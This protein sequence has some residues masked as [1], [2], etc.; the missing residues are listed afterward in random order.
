MVNDVEGSGRDL[1]E[2]LSWRK[3]AGSGYITQVLSRDSRPSGRHMHSGLSEHEAVSY[4]LD[5]RLSIILQPGTNARVP[6]CKR[7]SDMSRQCAALSRR[8]GVPPL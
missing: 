4:P 8:S 5:V 1:F 3:A 2:T 7:F 6:E